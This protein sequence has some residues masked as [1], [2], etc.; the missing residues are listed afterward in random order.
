MTEWKAKRFWS[1]VTVAR[2]DTGF[3]VQLDGRNV[4][5]PGKQVLVLPTHALADAVAQEWAAQGEY[6]A[7]ET[8]PFTRSANAALERVMPAQSDIIT[9]LAAYGQTDLLCYR[10][11]KQ[12]ALAARQAAGW[13]LVLDWAAGRYGVRLQVTS[14]IMPVDQPANAMAALRQVLEGYDAFHL[15]AIYDLITL[16]GSIIL[17]LAV[18]DRHL[19]ADQAFDLSRLDEDYQAEIWGQDDEAD[20]AA[21]AR[22]AQFLHAD[23]LLRLLGTD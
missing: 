13:D 9:M 17:G 20:T 12:S 11:D 10:A 21:A 3:H 15:T 8:M 2:A 4:K 22:R 7:P 16:S 6:I 18:A 14:G 23:H 5:T 19:G 1:S